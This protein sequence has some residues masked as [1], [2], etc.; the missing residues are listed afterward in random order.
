MFT[1]DISDWERW[2]CPSKYFNFVSVFCVPVLRWS[3]QF[4][5]RVF[6]FLSIIM[7]NWTLVMAFVIKHWYLCLM[8]RKWSCSFRPI[9]GLLWSSIARWAG[10]V[11][12]WIYSC[13]W[14]SSQVIIQSNVRDCQQYVAL[15]MVT[16]PSADHAQCCL[17]S[18]MRREPV[19]TTWGNS[20]SVW[21]FHA[22]LS[23]DHAAQCCGPWWWYKKQWYQYVWPLK[24]WGKT[25]SILIVA[26]KRLQ[27]H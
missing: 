26:P 8:D 21:C 19:I 6:T 2:P 18:V 11:H 9:T 27:E 17:T 15:Q 7:W 4:L 16:H 13:C 1:D 5:V 10:P 24:T 22:Q 25:S 20:S 14:S 12:K 3:L 23:T